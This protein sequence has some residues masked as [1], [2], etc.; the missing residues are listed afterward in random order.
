MS[1][2]ALPEATRAPLIERLRQR[3]PRLLAVYAFG[4]RVQGN[5][6]AQS[7]LDLA[8]LTEGYAEPVMLWETAGELAGLAGCDVDLLDLR[9]TTTV[10]QYQ[11]LM[12]GERWWAVDERAGLFEAAML[13]EKLW[14]DQARAGTLADIV[15][16]GSVYGR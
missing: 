13:T 5:A 3:V 12:D 10:M 11:V 9:A 8:V 4:S 15:A 1:L 2:S 7:D 16:R 6:D 14:L